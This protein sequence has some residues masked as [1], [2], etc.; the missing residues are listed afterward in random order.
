MPGFHLYSKPP[1]TV[2]PFPM[3]LYTHY[4]YFSGPLC[5]VDKSSH[6]TKRM[7]INLMRHLEADNE[8]T[9]RQCVIC[10]GVTLRSF[11]NMTA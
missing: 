7:T 2:T 3:V 4:Y 10:L 1:L 11:R 5:V 8:V 6:S 9:D